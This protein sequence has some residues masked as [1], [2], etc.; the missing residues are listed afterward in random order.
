MG[1]GNPDLR[2]E[3]ARNGNSPTEHFNRHNAV[4][5]EVG[6]RVLPASSRHADRAARESTLPPSGRTFH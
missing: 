4:Y 1:S 5:A 6:E 3:S 2:Q